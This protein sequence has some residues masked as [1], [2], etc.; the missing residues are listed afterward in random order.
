MV[1]IRDD[2]LVA[3]RSPG[4]FQV[5]FGRLSARW[6]SS[7]TFSPLELQFMVLTWQS[8]FGCLDM[9]EKPGA[10]HLISLRKDFRLA[11][12][13]IEFRC[14]GMREIEHSGP[15]GHFRQTEWLK[16]VSPDDL[17]NDAA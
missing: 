9:R 5:L 7:W 3:L 12:A 16:T 8:F 2:V 13:I 11:G 14:C 10:E 1:R 17:F 6:K 4:L 15:V